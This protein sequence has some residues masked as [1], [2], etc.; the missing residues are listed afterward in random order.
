M[1]NN[2]FLV[3]DPQD[4][5]NHTVDNRYKALPKQ[6]AANLVIQSSYSFVCAGTVSAAGQTDEQQASEGG[7]SK[8]QPND[9]GHL[10]RPVL[11]SWPRGREEAGELLSKKQPA[12]SLSS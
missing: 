2:S 9:E 11:G 5:Q 8:Q 4:K 10:D 6:P 12:T 3:A 1:P 7:R